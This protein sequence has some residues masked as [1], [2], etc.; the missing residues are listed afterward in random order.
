[1]IARIV[2]SLAMIATLLVSPWIVTMII[3]LGKP[4]TMLVLAP[5][6]FAFGT[7]GI[8]TILERNPR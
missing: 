1:M 5:V 6:G 7:A 4:L 2:F 3:E 8:A